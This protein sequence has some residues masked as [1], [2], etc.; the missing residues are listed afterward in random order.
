MTEPVRNCRAA[1]QMLCRTNNIFTRFTLLN[2]VWAP[3]IQRSW[4][5]ACRKLS[6]IQKSALVTRCCFKVKGYRDLQSRGFNGG[7]LWTASIVQ[8]FVEGDRYF[9]Q[10]QQRFQSR[11]WGELTAARGAPIGRLTARNQTLSCPGNISY[12]K[13]KNPVEAQCSL[14]TEGER[15]MWKSATVVKFDLSD[16]QGGT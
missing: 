14:P 3:R 2:K 11:P 8:K 15:A 4:D 10:T 13:H 9:K 7:S 5:E 6:V 12:R 16:L 1:K